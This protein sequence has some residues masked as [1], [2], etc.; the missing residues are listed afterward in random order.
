MFR[1]T[2]IAAVVLIGLGNVALAQSAAPLPV[3]NSVLQALMSGL[4]NSHVQVAGTNYQVVIRWAEQDWFM[5]CQRPQDICLA[6]NRIGAFVDFKTPFSADDFPKL[7]NASRLLKEEIAGFLK[8]KGIPEAN[9]QC[10]WEEPIEEQYEQNKAPE[11]AR[12]GANATR[13][14]VE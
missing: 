14:I 7:K 1:M 12:R 6:S 2:A 13:D 8:A 3:T 10:G 9:I 5:S 11:G 4:T